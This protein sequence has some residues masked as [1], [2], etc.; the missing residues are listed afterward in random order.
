MVLQNIRKNLLFS[1]RLLSVFLMCNF[2]IK[3]NFDEFD[4]TKIY[5]ICQFDNL[6]R[7]L[8][9]R[10]IYNIRGEKFIYQMT[11]GV[12]MKYVLRQ[13]EGGGSFNKS[14]QLLTQAPLTSVSGWRLVETLLKYAKHVQLISKVTFTSFKNLFTEL[15]QV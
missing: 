6:F 11:T 15:S 8:S 10:A 9:N 3:H 4:W 5:F 13:R 14:V 2:R 7:H 1:R 12:S